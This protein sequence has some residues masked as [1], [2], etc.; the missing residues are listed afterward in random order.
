[1]LRVLAVAVILGFVFGSFATAQDAP[2]DPP[3]PAAEAAPGAEAPAAEPA[4]Q[5]EGAVESP[6]EQP[7]RQEHVIYL[8]FEKLRETLKDEESSIVLPYAQF[9]KM[10]DRLAEPEPPLGAAGH[11]A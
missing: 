9:R 11:P 3:Q 4:A 10:W 8:P 5:A 7:V 2:P 1:M 6:A